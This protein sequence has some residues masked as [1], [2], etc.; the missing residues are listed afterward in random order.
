MGVLLCSRCLL[1]RFV[2]LVLYFC[3]NL[4]Y[5]LGKVCMFIFA[6]WVFDYLEMGVSV[7]RL[8]L[9]NYVW[10]FVVLHMFLTLGVR[11]VF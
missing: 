5:Y 9:S 2:I 4:W 7:A 8:V 3:F 10:V 11:V 6:N 1:Y